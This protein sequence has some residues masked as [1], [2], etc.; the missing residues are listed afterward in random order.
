MPNLLKFVAKTDPILREIMPDE[1]DFKNAALKESIED[2]CHSI[3]PEQLKAANAAYTSAAGMAANQWGVKRRVFIFTPGGAETDTK[4]EVMIN[5]SYIP[6]LRPN[7]TEYTLVAAYEGCFSIPLT[8]GLINRYDAIMATYHTPEGRKIERLM[9]GY[10]ARVFQHETDHLDGKLYDG[11]LDHYAGPDC[12]ER[13]VFKDEQE[14]KA[15][16]NKKRASRKD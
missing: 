12:L 9:E 14:M 16:E 3:L 2:M 8:I 4:P 15:W 1:R 11:K 13:V 10:E 7:E 6:Y 5:P